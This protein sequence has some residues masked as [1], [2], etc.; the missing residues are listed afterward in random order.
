M[1]CCHHYQLLEGNESLFTVDFNSIKFGPNAIDEIVFDV[2]QFSLNRVALFTDVLVK[3]LEPTQRAIQKLKNAG[4]DLVV[5][6]EISVE[7][8]DGSFQ[9][10]VSFSI[11]GK[12]DG[13]ISIGGGS[14][15]DTCKAA[16]LYSTYPANFLDYV[17]EPVGEGLAVPGPVKP[18]IACPTTS[19]T[20]S[21]CTGIAIFDFVSEKVKTGI[22]S[23][24]LKPARAVV[25]PLFTATL[26]PNVVAAS[27]FDVLCHALESYT[28]K[29]YTRRP[30]PSSGIRPLSQG[31]NPYSDVGCREAMRLTGQ[32]LVRAVQD[33]GDEKARHGMMLAATLA[34]V[35]FGNSGVHIPHGMS[36]SVAGLVRDYCPEGYPANHAL[37]PHGISVVVNA[38]SAFR[39]TASSNPA[40]HLESAELLGADLGDAGEDDAGELLSTQIEKMM[41][42]TGM[43]N[44]IS[45]VGYDDIDIENLVA[46]AFKQQRLLQN[47]PCS[48]TEKDL[49]KLYSRA[50]RYW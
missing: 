43:P 36:Y 21:E 26:K 40:R 12:F 38:P 7:P 28:A 33:A 6:D 31:A 5:Y 35:A 39:Y 37:V 45:G 13:F 19:G 2:Q 32:Y 46:G 8:T 14:V 50:I 24:F 49:Y 20:G 10:A 27:G 47:A 3:N 4:I 23:S 22:A 15:I 44:G 11:E 34:G 17:N 30:R 1:V 18:H 16:N 29:P 41:R 9:R 48:V 42:I 25:D